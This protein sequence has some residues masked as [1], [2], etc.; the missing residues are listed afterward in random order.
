MRYLTWI[1]AAALLGCFGCGAAADD[2]LSGGSHNAT[3]SFATDDLDGFWQGWAVPVSA[4]DLPLQLTLGFEAFG[5]AP[6]QVE[7]VHYTFPAPRSTGTVD[8]LALLS[9]YEIFYS[10]SGRLSMETRFL[11]FTTSGVFVDEQ[12]TKDLFMDDDLS[13]M[14]GTENIRVFE[15]GQQTIYVDSVLRLDRL[16]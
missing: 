12:I 1:L 4:G 6:S 14:V 13:T 2:T 5:S 10:G 15:G 8:Y 7:L 3:Q 9:T 11:G 16:N